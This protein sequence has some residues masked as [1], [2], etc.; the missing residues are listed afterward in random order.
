MKMRSC[1]D[2][3][4]PITLTGLHALSVE[5]PITVCTGYWFSWIAR[6]MFAAPMQLVRIACSGKYSQVGTC[7]SAAAFTTMSA[8]RT[9]AQISG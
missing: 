2:L 7:F 3:V 8:S 9:A 5:M 6:T 1:S 4:M